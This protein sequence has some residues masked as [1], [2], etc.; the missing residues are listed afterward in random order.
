MEATNSPSGGRSQPQKGGLKPKNGQELVRIPS[1]LEDD[2]EVAADVMWP[3]CVVPGKTSST[4]EDE[5][6]EAFKKMNERHED[7]GLGREDNA[8]DKVT[9]AT[10]TMKKRR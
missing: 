10:R 3:V 6:V 8:N 9:D 4:N 2:E 1:Q 5:A 7:K